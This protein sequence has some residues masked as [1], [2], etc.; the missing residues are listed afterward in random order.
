MLNLA[1]SSV[2]LS[3]LLI[4]VVRVGTLN[5]DGARDAY[6]RALLFELIK[7]NRKFLV[8]SLFFSL[9]NSI[10]CLS[11]YMRRLMAL[12]EFVF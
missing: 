10:L 6:K 11:M 1:L 5:M 4:S 12:R 3:Y 8:D 7:Q 2:L 9:K